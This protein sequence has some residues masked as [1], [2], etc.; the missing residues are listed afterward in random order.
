MRRRERTRVLIEGRPELLASLSREA[1]QGHEV[2]VV[3]EPREELVL[4]KVREDAQRSLFYLGEALMCSCTVS[5]DGALGFGMVLGEDADIAYTLA[6]VDASYAAD[7][8]ECRE[9][10]WEERLEREREH[11]DEELRRE[12]EALLA[13]RVD[14]QTMEAPDAR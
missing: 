14:F 8:P 6:V 3:E 5:I 10:A 13:T 2:K 7:I 12:E 11:L 4:L 9:N 1:E